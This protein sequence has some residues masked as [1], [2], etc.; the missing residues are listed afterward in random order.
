LEKITEYTFFVSKNE[1]DELIKQ[2]YTPVGDLRYAIDHE[3][4]NDRNKITVYIHHVNMIL[5]LL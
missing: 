3:L 5:D 2:G 1:I 4:L